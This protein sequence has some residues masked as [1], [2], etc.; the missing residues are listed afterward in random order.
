MK[1]ILANLMKVADELEKTAIDYNE[2]KKLHP[3]TKKT[4][5]DPLFK[6]EAQ[7]DQGAKA[8]QSKPKKPKN[9]EVRSFVTKFNAK[10]YVGEME[11]LRSDNSFKKLP[12]AEQD[13][14]VW[15]MVKEKFPQDAH[16]IEHIE[17]PDK[18]TIL[19]EIFDSPVHYR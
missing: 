11:K 12:E 6:T 2:Y 14:I 13:K 7:P 10:K 16:M 15:N 1:K 18:Q 8:P 5:S 4:P 19:N 9:E 3:R 17:G